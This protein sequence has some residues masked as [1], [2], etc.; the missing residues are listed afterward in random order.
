V[1][2]ARKPGKR[3]RFGG[4]VLFFLLGVMASAYGGE[5]AV[6][7]MEGAGADGAAGCSAEGCSRTGGRE[8]GGVPG[9]VLEQLYGGVEAGESSG[10]V[11]LARM[12][13]AE[14]ALLLVVAVF[15]GVAGLYLWGRLGS[16]RGVYSLVE[17]R[18]LV[19]GV[20]GAFVALT[21]GAALVGCVYIHVV[22]A[23][24][25]VISGFSLTSL[26]AGHFFGGGGCGQ[27]E[28]RQVESRAAHGGRGSVVEE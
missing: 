3:G 20:F 24:C 28:D 11:R 23:V 18:S 10:G 8:E 25:L 12:S 1:F 15:W 26:V 7:Q 22:A 21:G 4:S 27:A 6:G 5:A 19:L 14:R 16:V 17:V 13:G 2:K 9:Y